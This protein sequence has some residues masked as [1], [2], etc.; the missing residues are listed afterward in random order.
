M[1]KI[2]S[3]LT[4]AIMMCLS[5]F[6]VVYAGE[7]THV[8]SK[9]AIMWA[10]HIYYIR[11]DQTISG[12][13]DMF[14]VTYTMKNR[15]AVF[16]L[17]KEN[18][19]I[20]TDERLELVLRFPDFISNITVSDLILQDGEHVR[21]SMQTDTFQEIEHLDMDGTWFCM[22]RDA[23]FLPK[24]IQ[25]E[26]NDCDVAVGSRWKL[27]F[28][29]RTYPRDPYLRKRLSLSAEGID[30]KKEGDEYVF[31]S[32]GEGRVSLCLFGVPCS[33]GKVRVLEKQDLKHKMVFAAPVEYFAF[34]LLSLRY[35]SPL[36]LVITFPVA[37]GYTLV[38]YFRMI[39]A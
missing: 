27:R 19:E 29:E 8:E 20:Y 34:A 18:I 2:I 23:L 7:E 6:I 5:S 13:G 10:Q 25:G 3:A 21:Q 35:L 11:F 4:A 30:M 31:A 12:M 33:S 15:D 38:T 36:G 22:K 26:L 16:E 1:K 17:E 14:H 9:W 28:T 24:I 32:V 39:F 37:V